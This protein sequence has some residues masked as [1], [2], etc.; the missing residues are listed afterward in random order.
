MFAVK[1][2]DTKEFF[3]G[4]KGK[5]SVWTS[6]ILKAE[7]MNRHMARAQALALISHAD[8]PAQQKPVGIPT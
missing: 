3:A 1:R 8:I 6:D 2:K 4:F 5:K 7:P